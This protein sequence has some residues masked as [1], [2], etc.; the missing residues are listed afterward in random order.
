MKRLDV[1]LLYLGL[2]NQLTKK[3]GSGAIILRKEFFTKLGK[4]GQIPKNLRPIVVKEMVF[5][6]LIKVINRDK[7]Q[8]LSLKIDIEKDISKLY[9]IARINEK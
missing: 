5:K 3:F 2:H 1:G 9:R 7:I 4:H 6:K 8:I